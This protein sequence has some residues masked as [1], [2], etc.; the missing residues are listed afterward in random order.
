MLQKD[1]EPTLLAKETKGQWRRSPFAIIAMVLLMVGLLGL[2]AFRIYSN[3]SQPSTSF[4]W[5]NRGFSDFHNGTY[6]PAKAFVDGK[7]PYSTQVAEEY[8]MAR[9]TPPYSPVLFLIHAPFALFPLAIS[10]VLFFFFNFMWLAAIAW[11]VIRMSKQTFEWFDFLAITNLLLI[12]RPGHITMFSGYF[13]AEIVF[14]CLIALHYSKTRPAISGAGL[15]F[16]SIKPNFVI[17]LILLMA[18]RKDLKALILGC[19]FCGIAAGIG[20]GWLSYHNGFEQVVDDVRNG[21]EALHVDPTEMPVNTWTRVDLM[22]MYAK[23]VDWAPDDKVYLAGMMVI[24]SLVGAVLWRAAS[25]ESNIGATGLTA[26]IAVLT[27]LLSLYHHSYDCLIL[28]VPTI[29]L[30]LFGQKTIPEIP[31]PSRWSIAIL[32]L[33]PILNYASTKSVMELLSLEPLSFWWQAVTLINGAC[34]LIA[35]LILLFHAI[36]LKPLNTAAG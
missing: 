16:A 15:V 10:R 18:F 34:L 33:I 24:V 28:A 4:D 11:C 14:G 2:T 30:L 29:G 12:S 3:Y 32:T 35:L 7:S 6:F 9:A 23:V 25:R 17:P 31:R 36:Q 5:T 8:N 27:L 13:T 1:I 21:Q 19:L 26:F 20:L 22:G